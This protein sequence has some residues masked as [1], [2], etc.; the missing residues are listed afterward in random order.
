MPTIVLD[1]AFDAEDTVVTHTDK[2]PVLLE[3]S[4]FKKKK[5]KKKD[6]QGSLHSIFL[7]LFLLPVVGLHCFI[8]A[9]FSCGDQG[10]LFIVRRGLLIVVAS[11]C[12]AQ[13]L[14]AWA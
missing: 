12:G 6:L 7:I 1:A 11:R 3:K 14:G 5:K 2:G 10:S 4:F 8:L 13:V 9:F